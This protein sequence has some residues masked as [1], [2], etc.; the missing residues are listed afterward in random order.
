MPFQC[1]RDELWEKYFLELPT[2]RSSSLLREEN[3]NLEYLGSA[4]PCTS[5][6][7]LFMLAHIGICTISYARAFGCHKFSGFHAY[8]SNNIIYNR[9]LQ[10]QSFIENYNYITFEFFM[11]FL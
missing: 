3:L 6:D 10:K 9:R 4:T 2:I 5:S 1:K 7:D 11:L 8:Y